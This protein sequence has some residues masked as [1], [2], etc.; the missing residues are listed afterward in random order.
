MKISQNF[1]AFSEYMNFK[2]KPEAPVF[3]FFS[4]VEFSDIGYFQKSFPSKATAERFCLEFDSL[5]LA[6]NKRVEGSSS[7]KIKL[8]NLV[9]DYGHQ[10]K[11]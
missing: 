6:G 11:A 5:R 8:M 10:M 9:T 4:L 3:S 7:L 1:V 2:N